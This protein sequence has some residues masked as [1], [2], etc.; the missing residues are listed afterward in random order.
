MTGL[1]VLGPICH[2]LAA[3]N[4]SLAWNNKSPD[5][6]KRLTPV[7][8]SGKN[9]EKSGI[10]LTTALVIAAIVPATAAQTRAKS[11]PQSKEA[12]Y[13]KCS[14]EIGRK[15]G[16]PGIQYSNGPKYRVIPNTHLTVIDQCVASGGR[17]D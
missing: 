16:Q 2:P 12:L 6:A 5:G 3:T 17:V 11:Q 4:K 7:G 8:R 9:R 10:V 1:P 13:V 14:N 15:Y